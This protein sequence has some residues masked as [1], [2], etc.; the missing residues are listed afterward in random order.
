MGIDINRNQNTPLMKGLC[1]EC[2][3]SNIEISVID[4]AMLCNDCAASTRGNDER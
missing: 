1:H 4:G 3:T 2:L